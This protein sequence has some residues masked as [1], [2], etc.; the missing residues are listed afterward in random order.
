MREALDTAVYTLAA[1]AKTLAYAGQYAYARRTSG[2]YRRPGQPPFESPHPQPGWRDLMAAFAEPFGLERRWLRQGLYPSPDWRREAAGLRHARAYQADIA[3]IDRRRLNDQ[4]VEVRDLEEAEGFPA[5]FRQ[6]FHW[7]SGG[8]FTDDSARLYDFQVEALFTGSAGAM[9]RATALALLAQGLAGRDP[10][11]LTLVD[12]ACGTGSFT[13]EVAR[14]FPAARLT[15]VDLSP[16]YARR[17][18][19]TLRSFPRAGA[20]CAPGEALPL[21][22]ASVDG[23]SSVYLFHELPPRVRTAV[24]GEVA[25][26]LKP[27]GLFVLADALRTGDNPALDRPLDV[28]PYG[29]HEPYF[30][31]WLALD[32]ETAGRSAGL[33][34]TGASQRAY[35]TRAIAFRKPG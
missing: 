32:I 35:L 16:A 7:Q 3:S 12:L 6:N 15:G 31:S 9:R 24:L 2:P 10:R 33:V 11:T 28:F 25:R 20:V 26:V 22:D 5:Y 34:P 27:G 21:A 23:L 17:A 1:T 19:R 29:F 13:R 18:A 8:W 4:P 14:T 30:T